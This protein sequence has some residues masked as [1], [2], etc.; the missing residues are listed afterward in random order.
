MEQADR[1]AKVYEGIDP[2]VAQDIAEIIGLRRQPP[3]APMTT[4]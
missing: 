4:R 1:A 2:L 3:T